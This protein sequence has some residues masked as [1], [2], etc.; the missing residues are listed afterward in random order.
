MSFIQELQAEHKKLV[1]V[2][3]EV[4][5]ISATD[6]KKGLDILLTI[7]HDLISHLSKENVRLYPKLISYK[8]E[9]IIKTVKVF[10][11]ETREITNHVMN[12]F[13]D[14]QLSSHIEQHSATYIEDLSILIKNLK[15]R[16][17]REEKYLYPLYKEDKE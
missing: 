4:E 11:V 13:E 17:G 7:K 16:I 5:K 15:L 9:E 12:F 8:D 10:Q 3:L 14:Y 6:M 1:D 2:L